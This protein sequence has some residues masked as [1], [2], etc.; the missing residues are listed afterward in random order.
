MCKKSAT[1]KLSGCTITDN[2]VKIKQQP[3]EVFLAVASLRGHRVS[4]LHVALLV[5]A[6]SLVPATTD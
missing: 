2:E 3:L 1:V 6:S 5:L 4:L